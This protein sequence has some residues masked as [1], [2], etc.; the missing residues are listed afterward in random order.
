MTEDRNVF[1]HFTEPTVT[2]CDVNK[3]RTINPSDSAAL[4]CRGTRPCESLPLTILPTI[5]YPDKTREGEKER[6]DS[7]SVSQSHS[8]INRLL[9]RT[10]ESKY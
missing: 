1:F 6:G 9:Q 5:S 2:D 8:P 7:E 4:F 10:K 3:S